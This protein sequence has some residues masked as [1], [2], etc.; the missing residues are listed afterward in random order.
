MTRLFAL[1][2]A[3]VLILA[4]P[5]PAQQ[6]VFI[7]IEAQPSLVQAQK[8]LRDYAERFRDL[9]GFALRSGWFGIALG[10]YPEEEATTILRNLRAARLIPRDS[11]IAREGEF[12]AQFWPDGATR[13][14]RVDLPEARQNDPQDTAPDLLEPTEPRETLRE[15]RQSEAQLSREDREEIQRALAWAGVYEGAI[16]AAFG[17]GT[18]NA[19]SRWQELQAFPATGVLTTRQRRAL[20]D[21][22]NAVLDGLTLARVED[23]AAGIAMT[24]PTGIVAFDRYE[25]PFAHYETSD[26]AL[27]DPEARVLLISQTGNRS[28]LSG[29]YDVLQ[30]LDI[31]PLNGSRDLRGDSFT[32]T[33]QDARRTTYIE[34]K[35]TD[36]VIKGF[37][38]VWPTGDEARRARLL[39][40]MQKSFTRLDGVLDATAGQK[41]A[42]RIDLLA[43]L[44]IRQPTRTRSGF[45][46]DPRGWV[47]TTTEAVDGCA[48]VTI[49]G[50]SEAE[51]EAIDANIGIALLRPSEPLAPSRIAALAKESPR[52]RAD[53][54]VAGYSYGGAL[55][56]PSVTFGTLAD[57]TGLGGEPEIKRLALTALESDAGGPVLSDSGAV[58][59]VLLPKTSGDRVLPDDVNFA[60][61]PETLRNLL[62]Q[63]G[64]TPDEA[65]SG[66][67]LPPETLRRQAAGMTVL[68]SCWG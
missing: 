26:G 59:G 54:A 66:P 12:R 31:V 21:A 49:D 53:V 60:A 43:G 35:L 15:A 13:L 67:A 27:A 3:L 50:A 30:T 52:L 65:S 44:E 32:I 14:P 7:Q 16:D 51:I 34:A 11:Y 63:A 41:A 20:L 39:G 18:R 48:R 9:N 61:S 40:I 29:L 57:L 23:Q 28:T 62:G 19:M 10:P 56:A 55:G 46:I 22:Y 1:F 45:F 24:L 2:F 58:L 38:L 8:S 68:V 25:A 6:Q 33:G 42:A 36:G 5:A 17:P 47:M 64:I 37:A 4:G